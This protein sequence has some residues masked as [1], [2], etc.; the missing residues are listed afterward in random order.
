MSDSILQQQNDTSE[1]YSHRIDKNNNIIVVSE[2]WQ[3]FAEDNFGENTILPENI[4]GSSLW[5]HIRDPE[6][7]HLYE[8]ILQ[9][10]R[11]YNHR[12]TLLFRCDSP[13][14]RR[15]LKLSVIPMEDDSVTFKSVILKTETRE[16]VEL[17]RSD[18]DRSDKF[19]KICSMCKKIET[20]GSEWEEVESAV[21]KL[22]LFEIELLPK[23]THGVCPPCF[24]VA[25]K[26]L[27]SLR[28]CPGKS[29]GIKP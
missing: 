2:N 26:E 13:E 6:T 14:K 17:L 16:P 8:M 4:I 18:R 11:Q 20:S 25:M 5:D 24:Q 10:V 19:I 22:K 23:F 9:K 21:Q 12:T 27:E 7:R 29:I 15:F 1:V 3:S 28:Q